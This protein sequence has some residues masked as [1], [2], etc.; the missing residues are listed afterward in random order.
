MSE[1]SATGGATIWKPPTFTT[2]HL[3]TE[4]VFLAVT[5]LHLQELYISKLRLRISLRLSHN[6]TFYVLFEMEAGFNIIVCITVFL[7]VTG[8]IAAFVRNVHLY[9]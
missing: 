5:E 6:Y 8:N 3:A 2:L 4:S 7:T 9:I 1:S